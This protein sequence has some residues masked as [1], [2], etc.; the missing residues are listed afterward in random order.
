MASCISEM[1]SSSLSLLSPMCEPPSPSMETHSPVEPSLRF[2]TPADDSGFAA[3]VEADAA[4]GC[5][6]GRRAEASAP[7]EAFCPGTLA[8][9]LHADN[10]IKPESDKR[11][12]SARLSEFDISPDNA[13]D[14]PRVW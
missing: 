4:F 2:G 12:N 14:V 6:C 10:A 7:A 9:L 11:Q 13:T 5:C 1:A 3:A 8:C